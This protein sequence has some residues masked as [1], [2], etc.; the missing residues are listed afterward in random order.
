MVLIRE[1]EGKQLP[2]Y[3]VSRTLL[4]AETRHTE[5]EKL[6]LTLI[7]AARKLCPYFQCHPIIVLTTFPLKTIQDHTAQ[8]RAIRKTRKVGSKTQ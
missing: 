4:E 5:L 1:E 6:V 7:I 8:A 2:V 3:Y